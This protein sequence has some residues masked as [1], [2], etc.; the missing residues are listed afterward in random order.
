[1]VW[2]VPEVKTK[3]TTDK[4]NYRQ[5][6]TE[7]I[8][9]A[10]MQVI[11]PNAAEFESQMQQAYRKGEK[12]YHVKAFKGSKDGGFLPYFHFKD[13]TSNQTNGSSAMHRLSILSSHRSGLGL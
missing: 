5:A 13:S 9:A 4:P 7:A 2:T 6:M 3:D 10:G 8:E 12:S 11:E 1:M